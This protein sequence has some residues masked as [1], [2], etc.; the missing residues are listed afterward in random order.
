ML[1]VC[2]RACLCVHCCLRACMGVCV[3]MRVCVSMGGWWQGAHICVFEWNVCD[4]FQVI[5]YA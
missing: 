5:I 4:M 1:F 2:V 3:C